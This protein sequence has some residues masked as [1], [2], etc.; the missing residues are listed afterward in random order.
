MVADEPSC[1]E[2]PVVRK[3]LTAAIHFAGER[4]REVKAAAALR[5]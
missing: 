2:E 4:L 1:P 5:N 3:A